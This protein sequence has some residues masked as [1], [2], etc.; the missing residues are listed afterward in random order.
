[1]S[2]SHFIRHSHLPL[3]LKIQYY[4]R[5]KRA[6]PSSEIEPA[7]DT[8]HSVELCTSGNIDAKKIMFSEIAIDG[9]TGIA[10][11]DQMAGSKTSDGQNNLHSRWIPMEIDWFEWRDV[12]CSCWSIFT[13]HECHMN[14]FIVFRSVWQGD[15]TLKSRKMIHVLRLTR[16]ESSWSCYDPLRH[17]NWLDRRSMHGYSPSMIDRLAMRTPPITE[18]PSGKTSSL[19][20][21]L[22]KE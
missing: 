20:W 18:S 11:D 22:R 9:R 8:D 3:T 13:V 12:I 21:I 16:V 1:M 2:S 19:T 10:P 4:L 7:D 15:T 14:W 17:S 5:I 6:W